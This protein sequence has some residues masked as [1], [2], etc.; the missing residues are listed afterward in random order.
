MDD[1]VVAMT[2]KSKETALILWCRASKKMGTVK[3]E[4]AERYRGDFL[5]DP[6]V[7]VRVTTYRPV[8][9]LGGVVNPGNL[10][11]RPG[12]TVLAAIAAAGGLSADAI[13][14]AQPVVV[15]AANAGGASEFANTT[16]PIFPGD[17]VEIPSR[18][19][20]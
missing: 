9:V 16:D 2:I 20:R 3:T 11:Y 6:N 13:P 17:V 5:R 18:L 8:S 7:T 19:I 4:I 10:V 12:M 14:G 15:R 1:G